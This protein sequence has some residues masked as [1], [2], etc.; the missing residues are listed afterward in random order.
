MVVADAM[1]AMALVGPGGHEIE[2]LEKELGLA[3][4]VRATSDIHPEQFEIHPDTLEKLRSE[5]LP[6][7]VNGTLEIKADQVL[8]IPQA[9][10]IALVNGHIV[11]V[12][13]ASADCE[14][15]LRVKLTKVGNSYS[16]ATPV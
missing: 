6:Y 15:P 3:I 11:E 2:A 9:G 12:P 4:F 14:M 10:L 16:R 1:V 5:E 8:P 13:E 7:R